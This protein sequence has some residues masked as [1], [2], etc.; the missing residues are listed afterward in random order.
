MNLSNLIIMPEP[1][2]DPQS[3]GPLFGRLYLVEYERIAA[4]VTRTTALY[5]SKLV[6]TKVQ[7][8]HGR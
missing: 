2:H 1:G 4:D 8:A 5:F 6:A 7:L 3:R